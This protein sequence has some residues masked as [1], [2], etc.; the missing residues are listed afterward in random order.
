MAAEVFGQLRAGGADARA[1]RDRYIDLCARMPALGKRVSATMVATRSIP[2]GA[3]IAAFAP[4]VV[5]YRAADGLHYAVDARAPLDRGG[6]PFPPEAIQ[7]AV[8]H[9]AVPVRGFD[10][11]VAIASD[12]N[13]RSPPDMAAIKVRDVTDE[14]PYLP[15]LGAGKN[16]WRREAL[17]AMARATAALIARIAAESNAR[18]DNGSGR[19]AVL[20]STRD[21]APREAI[22]CGRR[23][24][25]WMGDDRDMAEAVFGEMCKDYTGDTGLLR[26]Q[27]GL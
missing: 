11:I 3:P 27:I 17:P 21:I 13:A 18:V 14:N 22:T 10:P 6:E 25:Y 7:H 2:A 15:F 1:A 16:Q 19:P 5:V 12:P 20:V 26:E 4:D 8:K 23:P 24:V 9:F